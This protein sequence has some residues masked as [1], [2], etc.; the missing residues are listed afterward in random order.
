MFLKGLLVKLKNKSMQG[1]WG[2][3]HFK[4][5][6][7]FYFS[8]FSAIFTC[9]NLKVPFLLLCYISLLFTET[10][11]PSSAPRTA[12][13]TT[14][15]PPRTHTKEQMHVFWSFSFVI[16]EFF[17]VLAKKEQIVT[18]R[19]LDRVVK[20]FGQGTGSDLKIEQSSTLGYPSGPAWDALRIST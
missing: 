10:S 5:R 15:E 4:T 14:S 16:V 20:F 13:E 3:S 1:T 7:P 2:K 11:C 19:L 17:N 12:S 9:G 8:R 18:T 6:M